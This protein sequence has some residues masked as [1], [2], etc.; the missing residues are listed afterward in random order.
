MAEKLQSEAGSEVVALLFAAPIL[1]DGLRAE[2]VVELSRLPG[3]R[4]QRTGDKFPEWLEILK[5]RA[6]GVIVMRGGVMHVRGN[7][8]DIVDACLSDEAQEVGNLDLAALGWPVAERHRVAADNA[9]GQIG[10]YHFPGRP[11]FDQLPLEPP[12]LPAAEND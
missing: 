2:C 7:P 1:I 6:I 10:R 4:V 5:H 3:T 8:D 11:R 9:D 12:E